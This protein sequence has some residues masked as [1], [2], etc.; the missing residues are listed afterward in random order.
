MSN[1]ADL[2]GFVQE[3][4]FFAQRTV[5]LLELVQR[6]VT[7]ERGGRLFLTGGQHRGLDGGVVQHLGRF[8]KGVQRRNTPSL[9]HCA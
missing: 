9:A 3:A 1:Q 8:T 4:R 7:F 5:L 2:P 6:H